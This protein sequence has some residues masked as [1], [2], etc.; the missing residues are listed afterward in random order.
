MAREG[1]GRGNTEPEKKKPRLE[2]S[3]QV[4]WQLRARTH[5]PVPSTPL[6]VLYP[7]QKVPSLGDRG[8]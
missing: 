4:T 6:R 2:R 1:K 3:V 5:P 8:Q 7:S